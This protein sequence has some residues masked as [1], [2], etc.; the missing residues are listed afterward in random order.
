MGPFRLTTVE[1]NSFQLTVNDADSALTIDVHINGRQEGCAVLD[2]S[3]DLF[4][5]QDQKSDHRR[6]IN[7]VVDR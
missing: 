5:K 2:P 4:Y 3:R 7:A 1:D 6:L